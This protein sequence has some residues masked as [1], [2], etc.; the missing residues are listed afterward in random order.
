MKLS[1]MKKLNHLLSGVIVLSALTIVSCGAKKEILQNAG[2]TS[3][4]IVN[5]KTVSKKNENSHSIVAII[6]DKDD[7]QALCT[8]TIV[9]PE[10]ILTA[11]HCVDESPKKLHIVFGVDVQQTTEKD[12]RYAD[13]FVKHPNWNRHMPSGEGD[14]ALI[15]FKGSLPAGYAPV[16]LADENLKLKKGQK[17]FML[18]FGVT[19]GETE[20]GSGKLR[21]T[22]S[23]IIEQQSTNEYVS[24]GTKSSVCFGDSGGPAF[25]KVDKAYFQWGVASSVLNK[26][27]DE[28]SIHTALMNYGA[29]IK[30]TINKM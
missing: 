30:S 29:W 22:T 14:L 21:Q 13:K 20:V 6:A 15:H 9:S 16:T 26:S 28:A 7:G 27:C 19:D 3:S 5:G 1:K 24:D 8:G 11:A 25:V 18:G 17:I 12:I 10:V 2:L 4:D 23:I